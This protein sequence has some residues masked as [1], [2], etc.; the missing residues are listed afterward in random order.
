MR[1]SRRPPGRP[2]PINVSETLINEDFCS[3]ARP[4]AFFKL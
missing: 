4:E 2:F 1:L 3:L